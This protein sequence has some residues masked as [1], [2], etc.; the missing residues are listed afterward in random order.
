MTA[1]VPPTPPTTPPLERTSSG[2]FATPRQLE[3]RHKRTIYGVIG[4]LIGLGFAVPFIVALAIGAIKAAVH[5]QPVAFPT[6]TQA[7]GFFGFPLIV[8]AL[9][10]NLYDHTA[11]ADVVDKLKDFW[12]GKSA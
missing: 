4:M 8:I 10:Y 5:G 3:A 11:F 7:L 2:T 9:S 1:P 6:F 12:P